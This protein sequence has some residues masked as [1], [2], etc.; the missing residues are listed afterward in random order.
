M[1]GFYLEPLHIVEQI[2]IL[3]V[4]SIFYQHIFHLN[5]IFDMELFVI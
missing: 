1:L 2:Y 5:F 3:L 4:V